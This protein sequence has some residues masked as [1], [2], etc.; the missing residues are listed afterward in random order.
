[1]IKK[2]TIKDYYCSRQHVTLMPLLTVL[3]VKEFQEIMKESPF[4]AEQF[5]KYANLSDFLKGIEGD[6]E[7][8]FCYFIP[9]FIIEVSNNCSDKYQS[10]FPRI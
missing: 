9:T 2:S 3:I 6:F 1:M 7:M 10:L 4:G 5:G 8:T